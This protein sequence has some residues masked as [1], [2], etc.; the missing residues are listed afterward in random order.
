MH[1]VSGRAQIHERE[2]FSNVRTRALNAQ[3]AV[4]RA[5]DYL[6]MIS[7]GEMTAEAREARASLCQIQWH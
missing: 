5:R 3:G 2:L 6:A 7:I 4:I 1:G